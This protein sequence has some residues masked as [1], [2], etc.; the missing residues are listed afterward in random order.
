MVNEYGLSG[1]ERS[2]RLHDEVERLREELRRRERDASKLQPE[3]DRQKRQIDGL[4]R[5]DER[6]KREI[7]HL[8]RQLAAARRA[9]F[10]QA[11]PFA[12]DR[13]QGRGGRP[14][15]R[16]GARYGRQACRPR[17]ERVDQTLEAPVPTTCPDCGGSVEVTHVASQYQEEIPEVRPIVRRFEI[18]VGHCS[19]C[20]RRVQGRHALQTSD[21]LGA[22]SAQLGPGVVALV[23][24]LH[25]EMGV[26]LAKVSHVLRTTFGLQ[27]T[28][29]GLA[30]L[31]HRVA[32]DAAPS[33]TALCEQ[34][35]NAPVVT[36]DETG[37]RVG[38]LSHWLWAFVTPETTVYAICPGRGFA[39]ATTVLGADFAGVL[40]RDGWVSYPCYRGALHQTCL[41]HLLQRCKELQ[42]DH[43]NSL[44][45]GQVQAV[46]QT[47][48]DVRDRCNDGKLSEHG[49][50]SLRGR[51]V[52]RLGRLVDAPPPL[53]DAERF[54]RHLAREFDAVFLFLRDLTVDATN[55]RAEQAI[56]PA[57]VTRKVCGGNRTRH[58]ADSQQV[59]ASVVRTARQRRLDLP[60]LIATILCATGPVVPDAFGRP[61][62][63]A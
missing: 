32:R 59:L 44:W 54:A 60:P 52:A 20:Q 21:A 35:R 4:R 42:E 6:Q 19:Q 33:Y 2:G 53:D 48:L 37:W 62:P 25:T 14:G 13:P 61:P 5:Q 1:N 28:P 40:V 36:P 15:R 27:V 26:P 3:N 39:D 58:G 34:V 18:E 55:W 12:K 57:V 31:L 16:A 43:P 49:L 17:P 30:H 50:A 7:E 10:R 24:E 9:G 38:A 8:K 46:L 29:G 63:P 51:L 47:G 45:A 41:N 56:R 23:V 22:A 11:A